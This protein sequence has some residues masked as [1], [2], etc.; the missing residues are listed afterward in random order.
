MI[1]QGTYQPP[2]ISQATQQVLQHL[3]R[4]DLPTTVKARISEKAFR[5]KLQVWKEATTTSPSGLHLGHWKALV[6]PH[7]HA[8]AHEDDEEKILLD[9]KQQELFQAHLSLLNYALRWG[10]SFTRWKTV[11][12][13]MIQKDKNNTKIHRLRVIHIYEA[14]YNLLLGLKWRELLYHAEDNNLLHHGQF[15]SR[16]QRSAPDLVLLEELMTEISRITR[17]S[18]L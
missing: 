4:P 7:T 11:V 9:A 8:R 1:L 18:L 14:D 2:D 6:G 5:Q 13:V 12:N 16:P 17:K 10:Y 15:G 3:Q